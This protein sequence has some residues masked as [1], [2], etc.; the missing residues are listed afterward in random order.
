MR[1]PLRLDARTVFLSD[2]HLGSRG[3]EAERLLAFLRSLRTQRLVL[4]G[5]VV[6]LW[7]LKRDVYWPES[8]Q[9]I[10]RTIVDF[11]RRGTEVIYV[12]GNHDAAFREL[13]GVDLAGV[14][15]CHDLVHQCADGRRF[16]VVHGDAFDG[17]VQ[18]SGVLRRF[19]AFM[20]DVMIGL[21]RGVHAAR[22]VLGLGRWSLATWVKERVPDARRYVDRFERA[23][24]HEALRRGL[25]GVIC[26]HI[27]RPGVRELDGILYCNDGDWVE[28]CTCRRRTP[29]SPPHGPRRP[30]NRCSIVRPERVPPGPARSIPAVRRTTVATERPR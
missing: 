3:C 17:A 29:A 30:R 8:H 25:D 26:G 11:A 24:A 19:G 5:D 14:Q 22:R 15:V 12:P 9:E 27:H 23:A 2:V 4:V 10:L 16:L 28:H 20:Y 18:F 7:S 1:Q 6:D 13:C 21:G